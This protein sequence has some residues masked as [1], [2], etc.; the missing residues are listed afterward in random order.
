MVSS[1]LPLKNPPY[2]QGTVM[3]TS[4]VF[5]ATAA[6]FCSSASQAACTT[7]LECANE[8]ASSAKAAKEMLQNAM[9]AGAVIAFDLESCPPSWKEY[10]RAYGRFVRGIDKSIDEKMDPDGTRKPGQ[11]QSDEFRSHSHTVTNTAS[12]EW[13]HGDDGPGSHLGGLRPSV[14]SG[15]AGGSETRPKNVALLYC[16]KM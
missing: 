8:A 5:L 11:L 6:I 12:G 16:R 14:G 15:S 1:R 10:E 2:D 7:V 13:P 4:T 3:K 9:P